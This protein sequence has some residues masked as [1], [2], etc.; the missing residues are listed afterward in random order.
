[1]G[2]SKG[3]AGQAVDV[4]PVASSAPAAGAFAAPHAARVRHQSD[5]LEVVQY[6]PLG[7]MEGFVPSKTCREYVEQ[8]C[9]V[10]L[11]QFSPH[12]QAL[13]TCGCE[14]RWS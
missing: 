14:V 3:K 2:R 10:A 11:P 1:M 4:S 12:M 8:D 9:A 13:V 6:R 5:I 7:I